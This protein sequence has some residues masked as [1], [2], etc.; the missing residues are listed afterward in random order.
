MAALVAAI[1]VL[2]RSAG[3]I[4]TTESKSWMAGTS[5]AM[6]ARRKERS[7]LGRD[8]HD[9][10]DDDGP[11]SRSPPRRLVCYPTLRR[12]GRTWLAAIHVLICSARNIA[13]AESKSWMAGTRPAMTGPEGGTIPSGSGTGMPGP[14]IADLLHC[15]RRDA[16][17]ATPR[18]ARHGRTWLA[19]IHVLI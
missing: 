2:L 16:S 9:G 17:S 12:H 13:T 1:H 19:A 11:S 10:P 15:R 5:P 7:L 4:A 3:D 18:S 6:T 14:K 8:W